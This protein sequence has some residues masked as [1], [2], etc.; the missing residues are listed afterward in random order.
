MDEATL[1]AIRAAVEDAF[2]SGVKDKRFIDVSRVPLIC[3]S[4]NQIGKDI[5]E[6]KDLIM[7][8][9]EAADIRMDGLVTADQFWPVRTVV[10]GLIGLILT[11]V[12]G[13]LIALVVTK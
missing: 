7:D 2:S 13:A 4:I 10:Y 6:I 8:N 11:A 1:K 5:G 3:Q 9:K 12:A